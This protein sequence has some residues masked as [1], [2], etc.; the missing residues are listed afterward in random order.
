M[1]F[2]NVYA[3]TFFLDR[4]NLSQMLA[5]HDFMCIHLKSIDLRTSFTSLIGIFYDSGC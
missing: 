1:I 5:V 3:T 2:K 4:S